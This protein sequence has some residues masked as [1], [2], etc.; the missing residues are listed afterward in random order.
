[1]ITNLISEQGGNY[2]LQDVMYE[3]YK[4]SKEGNGNYRN[5]QYDD[6]NECA[7]VTNSPDKGK[8]AFD[9]G[10]L[11]ATNITELGLARAH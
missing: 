1:M 10:A 4:V 3:L 9:A 2:D 11:A 7:Q 8:S 6:S 5:I